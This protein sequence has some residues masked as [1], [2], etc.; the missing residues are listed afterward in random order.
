[1]V[2]TEGMSE[3]VHKTLKRKGAERK[4]P[5]ELRSEAGISPFSKGKQEEG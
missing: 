4:K 1:M 2:L 5:N 3:K